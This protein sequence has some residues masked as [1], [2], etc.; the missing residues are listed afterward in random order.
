MAALNTDRL[1]VRLAPL[2]GRQRE[3]QEVVAR[4]HPEPAGEPDRARRHREDPARP[5]RRGRGTR[6]VPGRGVLGG[7]RTGRRPRH[8]P[9]GGCR[10][11]RHPGSPRAGRHGDDR[12]AGGRPAG[13][14]RPGQLRAPG[15]GSGGP[16]RPPAPGLRLPVDPHHQPRA[17]R[18]GRRRAV[19]TASTLAEFDA[20]RLFE[21]RARLVRPS[22]RLA[23]ENAAAV[24]QVCRRWTGCRW[25]SSWPRPRCGSCRPASSR[26]TST[27]SS[28]S[29]SAAHAPRPPGIRPCGRPSTG[30]MT[31]ST[32]T[33]GRCSGGWR[34]SPAGSRSLRSARSP[35]RATLIPRGCSSC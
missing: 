35:P 16:G 11:A 28:P 4:P 34:S 3:L 27:T 10:R 1:P 8:R 15:G 20:V 13:A 29:W 26:K 17:A 24:L 30:A 7:V 2:V 31:C 22:F 19:P 12:R 25:R 18:R 21:E 6:A 14:D 5:G 33:S 23:E 9:A 32:P